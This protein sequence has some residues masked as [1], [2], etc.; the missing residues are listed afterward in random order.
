MNQS[1][2]ELDRKALFTLEY[3][4]VLAL[5]ME[6]TG[7]DGARERAQQLLPASHVDEV[8]ERL[9]LT[10]QAR[11]LIGRKGSPS[12]YGVKDILPALQR[13]EKG[14]ALSPRELLRVATVLRAARSLQSYIEQDAE[15]APGIREMFSLLA[16][17]KTLE[18]RITTAILSEDEISDRASPELASIRRKIMAASSRIKETLQRM[19]RTP[20]YQKYLQDPIVTLRGDRYVVPVKTEYRAEVPG[21]VHDMSGS[22]ATCFVEPMV[23]VEANNELKVLHAKEADEIERILLELSAFVAAQSEEIALNYDLIVGIDFVFAKARL[24]YAMDAVQPEISERG[25]VELLRARHPLID[26]SK[27]VPIDIHLG[28][29][30]DTMIVTGPN[31]GGKTVTL[32]TLGLLHLMAASGLHIPAKEGSRVMVFDHVFSDIGDEQSIEQSLSTFSSHMVNLIRILEE[33]DQNSLV[34]LDELGA[35]TDPIEGAALATAVLE[36]LRKKGA[37]IAATTHYPELKT[38]ALNTKGVVNASCE[39][40]VETLRPTYRLIF[41]MPGKS[42]AYAIS[43]RLGMD[44]AIVERARQLT[45]GETLA[46]E[47]VLSEFERQRQEMEKQLA[48]ARREREEAN[49][50]RAELEL[51]KERFK[52]QR[53]KEL[54]RATQESRRL[55]AMAREM[56][57]R[58]IKELDDIKKERDAADFGDKLY[59]AKQKLRR[60]LRRAAGELD[61]VTTLPQEPTVLPRP[62]RVGDTVHIRTLDKDAEVLALPDSRGM[63][64]VRAGIINTKVKVTDLTL[65]EEKGKAVERFL[66]TRTGG[67]KAVTSMQAELDL[68]GKN[69]DEGCYELDKYLDEAALHGLQTVTVIHGKGTGAL[70]NAVR[71]YLK[72]HPHVKSY[73]RGVYGEGEDGVTVV[74][75]L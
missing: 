29:G 37:H 3:D 57:N 17:Q 55:V 68:R 43:L 49:L 30:V 39:F 46:F 4:K 34:L 75:L 32:K 31:T 14:A 51:Q 28:R 47:E 72:G 35:G 16:P 54:E 58:T 48:A 73:R 70:R 59:Q 5:L 56:Y 22:G 2:T 69:G 15:D 62:L 10:E 21:L 19:I 45:S 52:A 38:F 61:P 11:L 1:M 63:V 27:V 25:E 20:S 7:C 71:D 23:V 65:V 40:D 42:N 41:G 53:D 67:D 50:L 64:S 13:A 36:R 18:E 6:Q 74:E 12:I 44:P 33:A 66:S 26:K 9:A 60:D 24:A 8:R